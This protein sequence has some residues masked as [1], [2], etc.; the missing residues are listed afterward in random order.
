MIDLKLLKENKEVVIKG[1][2]KKDP[3]FKIEQLIELDLKVK[4]LNSKIENLRSKKNELT[5][6]AKSGITD[7][8]RNQSI[9]ISKEL[10]SLEK[11]MEIVSKEFKDLY[12]SCPNL[13]FDDLPEGGKESN[14]VVKTFNEKPIYNF[15][16]KNH[17]ELGESNDWF[18]LSRASKMTKSGFVF[19]KSMGA[20]VIYALTQMMMENNQNHGFE[21]CL[22]PYAVNEESLYVAGN[23]PK[24]KSEVFALEKDEL[25]LI[26][27]AEVS[28][29]NF[30]RDE[31]LDL[32]NLPIRMT[33]WTPCF[34]R[35]AGGYGKNERGLIRVH[36]FEKVELVS[37]CEPEKSPGEL[38]YMVACA[39]SI[40]QKLGLHYRVSLL[41]AQDCSFQSAKTYDIEVWLPGQNAYYEVSSASNCTDFQSRRGQIRYREKSDQKTQLVHTL[42]AS[43]LALSRVLVA[44]IETYQ[45]EDGSI[46]LPEI[47]QKYLI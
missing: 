18:D 39:E 28:L 15:E 12:L 14:K 11:E 37:L 10:S 47:L 43:S 42:N 20:K 29:T 24:F 30:Y 21:I 5:V 6:L 16:L 13:P 4:D 9:Y 1:I 35:E 26:P 38:D 25:Y 32:K 46:V 34:R 31:I 41:A 40:L 7:E 33:S 19:Y 36:Q 2:L 3:T 27:T 23:F 44:L 45:Q 22:P 8:I 17:V